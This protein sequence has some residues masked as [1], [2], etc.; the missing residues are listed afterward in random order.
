MPPSCHKPTERTRA[1][2]SNTALLQF[3]CL[4]NNHQGHDR[5]THEEAD[6][7]IK[8]THAIHQVFQQS[9]RGTSISEGVENA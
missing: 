6:P 4:L 9:Q 5:S 1:L 2:S 8:T 3:P 7:F